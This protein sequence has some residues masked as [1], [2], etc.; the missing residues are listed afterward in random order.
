[1]STA[2]IRLKDVQLACVIAR[3][4]RQ[5]FAADWFCALSEHPT[6]RLDCSHRNRMYVEPDA[7][8]RASRFGL[9]QARFMPMDRGHIAE[10]MERTRLLHGLAEV[11]RT[12]HQ[13]IRAL[14]REPRYVLSGGR[15]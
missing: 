15:A 12:W 2:T 11:K 13:G 6:I 7:R 3:A 4:R 1:M 5:S 10:L 14:L 8:E 9:S